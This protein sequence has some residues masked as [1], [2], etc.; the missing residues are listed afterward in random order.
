MNETVNFITPSWLRFFKTTKIIYIVFV[1]LW[2]ALLIASV[3]GSVLLLIVA[4]WLGGFDVGNKLFSS[5]ASIYIFVS[6]FGF[7]FYSFPVVCL[8]AYYKIKK[9]NFNS[10]KQALWI[11]CSPILNLLIMVSVLLL[12]TIAN[13]YFR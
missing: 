5:D 7:A 3:G 12:G 1:V 4:F 11:T 8:I 2:L 13:I 9:G 6:L 10:V